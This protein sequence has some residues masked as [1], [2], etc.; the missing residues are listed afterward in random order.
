MVRKLGNMDQ[1]TAKAGLSKPVDDTEATTKDDKFDEWVDC[2]PRPETATPGSEGVEGNQAT[3]VDMGTNLTTPSAKS[4]ASTLESLGLSTQVSA[5]PAGELVAQAY[6][7]AQAIATLQKYTYDDERLEEL[8]DLPLQ[9][10]TADDVL[11]LADLFVYD[12]MREKA[13]ATLLA[14]PKPIAGA[15]TP[16]HQVKLGDMFV[17]D[18]CRRRTLRLLRRSQW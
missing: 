2:D 14:R 17:Y 7:P 15:F 11:E 16:Y 18:D 6:T 8:K 5:Q 4:L 12:D 13:L 10:F 9:P 3:M 1:V